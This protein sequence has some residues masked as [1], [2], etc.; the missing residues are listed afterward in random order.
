M[1]YSHRNEQ[2]FI[3]FL[4]RRKSF[5]NNEKFFVILLLVYRI[6]YQKHLVSSKR[7]ILFVCVINTEIQ[8]MIFVEGYT[9]Q[10]DFIVLT[11]E[12]RLVNTRAFNVYPLVLNVL[13][14]LNP[15][16]YIDIRDYNESFRSII[17]TIRE[18]TTLSILRN[19]LIKTLQKFYIVKCENSLPKI[20]SN[21]NNNEINCRFVGCHATCIPTNL[22]NAKSRCTRIGHIL[23]IQ[24]NDS[25]IISVNNNLFKFSIRIID[26]VKQIQFYS[27]K[28]RIDNK[29]HTCIRWLNA[30]R[31]IL[32][33]DKLIMIGT[34]VDE[35][36]LTT[37][38]LSTS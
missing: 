34:P 6:C 23:L 13:M 10:N 28:Y 16:Y 19:D 24:R 22:P 15:I 32:R 14:L 20:H 31:I 25:L 11:L 27:E 4:K 35:M 38:T 1:T 33:W 36:V 37:V 21:Y 9:N 30:I 8:T 29:F 18:L 7:I 2:G 3:E 5:S 17:K 26:F 12:F